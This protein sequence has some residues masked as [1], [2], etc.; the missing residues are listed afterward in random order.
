MEPINTRGGILGTR[1]HIGGPFF[2]EP[3]NRQVQWLVSVP[4]GVEVV[5]L[6][7]L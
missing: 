7:F 5:W 3:I 2:M 1:G 6:Q 4:Y